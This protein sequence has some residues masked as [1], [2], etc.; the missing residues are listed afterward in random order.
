MGTK[1]KEPP[2]WV[3]GQGYEDYVKDIK[4]W[5]LLKS[6]QPTEE[7]PV[8]YRVLKGEAKEA[9]KELS[10][11][12]IG[13]ADGL[14]LI[15]QKLDSLYLANKNQR[16]FSALET[17]EKFRR[18][19]HMNMSTF[20]L[21]FERLHSTVKTFNCSYPDGVLAYK[22]LQSARLSTEHE[23]LCKATINTGQWTY[24]SV[25]DQI[26]K[27]LSDISP[28]GKDLADKP[29]KVEPTYYGRSVGYNP[30]DSQNENSDEDFDVDDEPDLK[31]HHPHVDKF[32]S[33]HHHQDDYDIY[34]GR[35]NS[36]SRPQNFYQRQYKSNPRQ[37]YPPKYKNTNQT[38]GNKRY[39][40][41]NINK[42]KDSY[43]S[44]P[45]VP[46]PKD[47]RGFYTTC[48][49]CQSRYHWYQDC[50]HVDH[51]ESQQNSKIFYG[52]DPTDDV[53]I[54][55]FQTSQ[56][57][58]QDEVVC[59]V[60]ESF[61]KAVIDS[62]CP[63]NVCGES[64]FKVYKEGMTNHQRDNLK[65]EASNAHFRFGDS[66][67]LASNKKVYLPVTIGNKNMFLPTDVIDAE[68]PLLLSKQTL[69]NGEA[70]I[71]CA[72]STITIFGTK[73]PMLCTS[74]GHYAIPIRPHSSDMTPNIIMHTTKETPDN[75]SKAKKLHQQFGHPSSERLI[76]LVKNSGETNEELITSIIE[77]TNNCDICK[78]YKKSPPRPVVT[79]PV[80]TEFNQMIAMDIKVFKNNDIYFLHVIDH[81]TRFSAAA[82]LRSKKAEAVLKSFFQI[83][84]AVFGIPQTILSD[85]GGEFANK[86]FIDMCNNLNIK[87]KTTAAEAPWSNGLVE[88]HNGMIGEAVSKILEDINCSIEIA[89][90]WACNAKNS[91]QNIHGF[92]PYQLV[93]GKN[94]N[95]PSVLTNRLPALEGI[96]SSQIVA[97][98]IN[99]LHKARQEAIKMESSEKLRRALRAKVRTHNNTQYFRGDEVFYKRDGDKCWQRGDVMGQHG[100][101]VLIKIPTGHISVH[102]S[103]VMLTSNSDNHLEVSP[104]NSDSFP[105]KD[106]KPCNEIE[107][108][109]V[110]NINQPPIDDSNLNSGIDDVSNLNTG[111]IEEELTNTGEHD[112]LPYVHDNSDL[113]ALVDDEPMI[114]GNNGQQTE[115]DTNEPDNNDLELTINGG[116]PSNFHHHQM[117]INNIII[118]KKNQ[119]VQ[120][121]TPR[122]D[123]WR[124]CCILSRGGK[125]TGAYKNC[126]NIRNTDDDSEQCLDWKK[127]VTEWKLVE[128][129]VFLTSRSPKDFGFEQA[130]KKE[131]EKWE[132][133]KVYE[134]VEDK[135]QYYIT[136]KWIL[137]EKVVDGFPEK[138]ARLVAR[139]FEEGLEAPTD[140]PT[141]NKESLRIAYMVV[142]SK[143][144]IVNSLDVKAA[145]LQGLPIT[146]EVY[147]KPPK[148][149][150]Q[151]GKLWKLL[152]CVY[153]LDDA[154]RQFYLKVKDQLLGIGCKCSRY[155]QAIFTYY[156]DGYLAGLL[157]SH[158]DD[159]LWAGN[160]TFKIN[161]INNVKTTFQISSEETALF[162]YVGIQIQQCSTGIYLSQEKYSK[163]LEEIKIVKD[164]SNDQNR[165]LSPTE[166]KDL[167]R[168]IGRLNWLSTQTRPD[169]S[170]DVCELSSKI[171]DATTSTLNDVNRVIKK[172]K[173]RSSCM[174]FP[175]MNLN[176]LSINCYADASHGNL[177]DGGSQGGIYTEIIDGSNTCAI[178]WQSKR[179]RRVAKS[180]MSA[181]TMAMVDAVDSA[182]Y[183][184]EVVKEILPNETSN[185]PVTCYTDNLSLHQSAHKK[186]PV[187]D[188]RLR[189]ELAI[190]RESVSRGEVTLKWT[191]SKN[192]LANALT[193]KGCDGTELINRISGRM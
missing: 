61:D 165:P 97:D 29:I 137:N 145:F 185:L 20:L 34:Y 64:W 119:F 53:L 182:C 188:R 51:K 66:P 177:S 178:E 163:E 69:I 151:K 32:K 160:D 43:D 4:I 186:T 141:I 84:V 176:S 101:T 59:L 74:S 23:N 18:P 122:S 138:R 125:A 108:P 107:T 144:W 96:T 83:W 127:D 1:S 40:G 17:F 7:G 171:K 146:R 11:E 158:V 75:K 21:Q 104:E 6:V 82:V 134:T 109:G 62:G 3:D 159:F 16:I 190:I 155:D 57:T 54:S 80:A 189:I 60:G 39:I 129:N 55:L 124:T 26:K 120:Y 181:E 187:Q 114:N 99:A 140:A 142:A 117:D 93:F 175:K 9:A 42:L 35:F 36:N 45:T 13:S 157:M 27:I 94:P 70:E 2:V 162:R 10:V 115:N 100:S 5:Q 170:Y 143:G 110:M 33:S 44:S 164:D 25:K 179:I 28:V 76:K 111:M 130:K 126:L 180:T 131:L 86:D 41:I 102:T 81:L 88:R 79:L 106:D 22:L 172:A 135:G 173:H 87:F 31:Q 123:E 154:S 169:L 133:M 192:Q 8:I 168:A 90:C 19:G 67:A 37:N 166:V 161:I 38:N 149:A 78:K 48:R 46:N 184:K 30:D 113:P 121:K 153:G 65:E 174:F 24:Q 95:L 89:L 12:E 73:Q 112:N 49:K 77:I 152:R 15:L 147:L 92:S 56:P 118:P 103:R 139:G 58:S 50:P 71:N 72:N 193:K 98:N 132:T 68:L 167:R 148:E 14:K 191:D 105:V 52:T 91:L 47:D 150:Q 156:I 63:T 183:I 136:V 116:E 128:Q 85:N